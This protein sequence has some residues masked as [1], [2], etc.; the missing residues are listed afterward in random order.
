MLIY[1]LENDTSFCIQIWMMNQQVSRSQAKRI[2]SF[3]FY[4]TWWAT[5]G[6]GGKNWL[7]KLLVIPARSNSLL[8]MFQARDSLHRG[9]SLHLLRARWRVVGPRWALR[10]RAVIGGLVVKVVR[11]G[12]FGGA[13]FGR[14]RDRGHYRLFINRVQPRYSLHHF[15]RHLYL[16]TK[17]INYRINYINSPWYFFFVIKRE[18][19]VNRYNEK[20]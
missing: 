11:H 16:I 20:K 9:R 18:F 17:Y 3:F 12:S 14:A 19:E 15:L 5:Y 2:K 4:F 10:W 13:S 7:N 1:G 8:Q 6:K